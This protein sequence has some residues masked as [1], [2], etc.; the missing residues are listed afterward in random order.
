MFLIA[1]LGCDN[2]QWTHTST[3][4]THLF[5]RASSAI[6]LVKSD[7]MNCVQMSYSGWQWSTQRYSIH[8]AKPSFSHKCVH[9]SCNN[10]RSK[11]TA[12]HLIRETNLIQRAPCWKEVFMQV[13]PGSQQCLLQGPGRA[14]CVGQT[15]HGHLWKKK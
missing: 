4:D 11:D 1:K 14:V 2:M 5:F 13:M 9:H 15:Y 7:V 6:A 12:C 3:Q 8:D 10:I